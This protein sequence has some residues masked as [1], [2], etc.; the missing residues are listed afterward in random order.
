M[1]LYFKEINYKSEFLNS[2][3][4]IA[5]E[6]GSKNIYIGKDTSRQTLFY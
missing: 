5:A 1:N 6:E 2:F 3:K 4:I